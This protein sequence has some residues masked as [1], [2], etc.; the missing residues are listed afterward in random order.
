MAVVGAP[1]FDMG[2]VKDGGQRPGMTIGQDGVM[3]VRCAA[4]RDLPH[5]GF[6]DFHE[7]ALPLIAKRFVTRAVPR[8]SPVALPVRTRSGYIQALRQYH[9]TRQVAA[10]GHLAEDWKP[11]FSIIEHG[12]NVHPTA[13][14]LDSV[15][16]RGARVE[17][18]AVLVR[19]VVCPGAVVRRGRV[20]I[21]QLVRAGG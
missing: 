6:C 2:E 19:S 11:A 12:A 21:D 17:H 3:L 20:L 16:L 9:R 15:A 7:Q 14:L 1:I 18:G 10:G 13:Q 8:P 5:V 4:L